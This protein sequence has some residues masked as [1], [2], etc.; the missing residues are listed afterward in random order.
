MVRA[1]KP[2]TVVGSPA[3]LQEAAKH[4][5]NPK[6]IFFIFLPFGLSN[7]ITPWRMTKKPCPGKNLFDEQTS[8]LVNEKA[9]L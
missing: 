5:N 1:L 6:I 4:S 3:Q 8:E 7:V 2:Y 9:L